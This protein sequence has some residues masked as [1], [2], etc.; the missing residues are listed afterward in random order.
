L[1][2]GDIRLGDQHIT[3]IHSK[4]LRRS[5]AV[6]SGAAPLYGKTVLDAIANS[7]KPEN[8]EKAKLALAQWQLLFPILKGIMPHTRLREGTPQLTSAQATLLQNLRAHLTK[9]PFLIL[10]EPFQG[11]DE[12]SQMKL[13]KLMQSGKPK[14]GILFLSALPPAFLLE[15]LP[16]DW[17][18]KLDEPV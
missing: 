6:V 2:T 16:V 15:K 12:T 5:I 13:L 8:R 7:R 14:K 18:K 10:D 11:L 4:D 17:V 1:Q 9:K 3:D